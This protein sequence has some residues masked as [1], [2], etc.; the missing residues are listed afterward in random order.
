MAAENLSIRDF[1]LFLSG[2][3][4][5]QKMVYPQLHITIRASSDNQDIANIRWEFH[6][7]ISYR[8][9]IFDDAIIDALSVNMKC[10]VSDF[11]WEIGDADQV[12]LASRLTKIYHE[13]EIPVRDAICSVWPTIT[14]RDVIDSRDHDPKRWFVD[15]FL[16]QSSL[17]LVYM[18]LLY[19]HYV[20]TTLP[21]NFPLP[22]TY[23]DQRVLTRDVLLYMRTPLRACRVL[24]NVFMRELEWLLSGFLNFWVEVYIS[25]DMLD[26]VKLQVELLN[27]I[28]ETFMI[29]L[30]TRS[31]QL[32]ESRILE[33][34]NRQKIDLLE[35]KL[36]KSKSKF[37]KLALT[38][39]QLEENVARQRLDRETDILPQQA[40]PRDEGMVFREIKSPTRSED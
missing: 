16:A 35:A 40:L 38:V 1:D 11:L 37:E 13:T 9:G 15:V 23:F 39:S 10:D 6:D 25:G 4:W 21:I 29:E 19:E 36:K 3:E 14:N 18:T 20:W 22:H 12:S 34:E 32:F 30:D 28:A 24:G 17:Y 26:T 27:S 7:G 5:C 33:S 31:S 2:S 8:S